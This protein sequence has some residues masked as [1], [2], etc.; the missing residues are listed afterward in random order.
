MIFHVFFMCAHC[1]SFLFQTIEQKRKERKP[2][3]NLKQDEETKQ[4]ILMTM[5]PRIATK[6]STEAVYST[7]KGYDDV[8]QQ[9]LFGDIHAVHR[10]PQTP[11]KVTL[12][13]KKT[14]E[15][16][17]HLSL[18]VPD[19]GKQRNNQLP[20]LKIDLVRKLNTAVDLVDSIHKK[21]GH[22]PLSKSF[23]NTVENPIQQYWAW[24]HQW[25]DTFSVEL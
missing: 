19:M 22:H 17:E 11:T 12:T 4:K 24:S 16:S 9:E 25:D 5:R 3:S 20:S 13:A 15:N 8:L 10:R 14:A 7:I 6:M 1:N 2:N 23:E 21:Q 18:L